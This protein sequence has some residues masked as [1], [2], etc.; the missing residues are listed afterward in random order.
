MTNNLQELE[1]AVVGAIM[2]EGS[3]AETAI[4]ILKPEHLSND[5]VK[6]VY[7]AIFKLYEQKSG[8]DILTV[9]QE[10][11][12]MN[13][14]ES[15]GGAYYVS[16]LT[17]RIASSANIEFHC[18]II[19]Q[20]YIRRRLKDLSNKIEV[21]T[22]EPQADCFEIL[23]WAQ[24]NMKEIGDGVSQKSSD[25]VEIIKNGVIQEMRESILN[26]K[27]SGVPISINALNKTTNGWQRSDLIILAGRPG[28]GKT[29]ASIEFLLYPALNGVPCA[30]FSLEMS[31]QQLVS[32][33]LSLISEMPVQKIINKTVNTYDID[34]LEKDGEILNGV[35]MFIDDTPALKMFDLCN[36]ARKLK[37]EK[38]I[39]LIV[40]DYIQLMSGDGKGNR[41][42]EISQISRGLKALAKELDLPIIALSQLSRKVE[43][44]GDKKPML[45]DLRE[46]GAI[47]QDADMVIFC[48]RPAE[49]G[50]T[51]YELEGNIISPVNDLMMFL[52]SKFRN[53]QQGEIKAKWI[54]ELTKVTNYDH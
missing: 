23:E 32:R 1:E 7:K 54:G 28:M 6:S 15:I 47:E 16:S 48:F 18:R 11:K 53:G 9:T 51:E 27:Q 20:D 36:K 26:G 21:K 25:P 49:Y 5:S 3:A 43:E 31:K 22:N 42:Q 50:I 38:N 33:M 8:I 40:I 12:K 4:P 13:V 52:I 39:E 2:L 24:T 44:R 41:E 46:S 10:L 29:S 30:M 37:R 14:L 17:N 35:P 34:L 19:I 45:S